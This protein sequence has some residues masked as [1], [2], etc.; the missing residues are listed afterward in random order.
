MPSQRLSQDQSS[1]AMLPGVKLRLGALNS[2]GEQKGV[3][4]LIVT[5]LIDLAR[6]RAIADAVVVT[7]DEDLRIAVQVAQSFGVR[8]HI[9]AAGDPANNVSTALQ[10]EA[11]SVAILDAAWFANHLELLPVPSASSVTE[12]QFSPRVRFLRNRPLRREFAIEQPQVSAVSA[13]MA[14][15]NELGA[16]A[17]RVIKEILKTTPPEKLEQLV[18]DLA[19]SNNIPHEYDG[20]L[21]RKVSYALSGRF[22]ST[23]ENR[24]IRELFIRA[25]KQ[26]S[27]VPAGT[28]TDNSAAADGVINPLRREYAAEQPQVSAVP[29]GMAVGNELGA[30]ADGVIKEILETTPPEK[31]EQLI[32]DL[33]AS[34]NVPHEY[35]VVL[36]KKVS[37][38]LSGRFLSG[39]EN[40]QIRELFI[41]AVNRIAAVPAGTA[42]ENE[43]GAAADDG[44]VDPPR[45]E[46]AVEQISAIPAGAAEN[47]E[48]GAAADGVIEEILPPREFAVAETQV[49]AVP[50]GTA[51]E[52]GIDAV[53]DGVIKEI[54]ETTPPEKLE[55]LLQ[56]L[57]TS[58]NIP[59]EYDA[60]LIKKVSCALSGRFLSGTENR[61]IR[62]LFI[63]AANQIPVVP[64]GTAAENEIGVADDGVVVEEVSETA[65]PEIQVPAV[66]ADTAVEDEI[67]A[68]VDELVEEVSEITPP[69]ILEGALPPQTPPAGE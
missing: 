46:F 21:I 19:T 61:Q 32:R 68:V 28:A 13:G 31:L 65:P 67:G 3:D 51:A 16:A 49:S 42:A 56:H 26:V 7:G 36:I 9:L 48:I 17:D 30:V 18:Q 1:L 54:L 12:T 10:M 15:V 53:A 6:N 47:S 34:N 45:E 2:A 4:S 69:E 41:R 14:V 38:A 20:A 37:Y 62:E 59:H 52:D 5:D 39:T 40:R 27:V 58:N 63:H 44:V 24:Q 60:I 55:Q 11:D 33:A 25:V 50:A 22:L 8:V 23:A 66:P 43:I 35:D 57:A 29:A 64:A